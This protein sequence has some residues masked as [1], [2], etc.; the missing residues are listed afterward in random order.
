MTTRPHSDWA[1]GVINGAVL[2]GILFALTVTLCYL[3]T[4]MP[5]LASLAEAFDLHPWFKSRN[6]ILAGLIGI[7]VGGAFALILALR[8][9]ANPDAPLLSTAFKRSLI[10]LCLALGFVVWDLGRR[11]WKPERILETAHFEIQST[12]SPKATLTVGDAVEA[13]HTAYVGFFEPTNKVTTPYRMKL[14]RDREEFRFANRIDSWAEA[15]YLKPF[16]YAYYDDNKDNPHHWMLHEATHQLNWELSRFELKKWLEEGIACYFG[17]SQFKGGKLHAGT[18]DESAYPVNWLMDMELTGKLQDD[19]AAGEVIPLKAIL[20]GEG[21]PPMDEAFN[22]YYLH[23]W[24]LVHFLFEYD[25][26]IHRGPTM[27]LIQDGGSLE[28]FERYLGSVEDFQREWY[29]YVIFL[30]SRD[31]QKIQSERLAR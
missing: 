19:I 10:Y 11:T 16:C 1:R 9:S 18:I 13:L 2:A 30:Q 12:A 22:E 3:G 4:S 15:Y 24:T 31:L 21:G 25:N 23:W 14:F 6:W 20:T 26:Q 27:K 17:A 7:I 28:Q 8:P 29:G 5:R